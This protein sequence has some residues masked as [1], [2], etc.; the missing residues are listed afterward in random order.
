MSDP[1]KIIITTDFTAASDNALDYVAALL[2]QGVFEVQPSYT[3]VHAYKPLTPYSK[4]PSIPVIK[5]DQLEKT[6]KQKLNKLQEVFAAKT[7][8][9]TPVNKL[10]GRGALNEVLREEITDVQL[11]VMGS[12][13]K[14]AFRRMT[15]G[16]NTLEV[17]NTVDCPLLAIPDKETTHQLKKI[18]MATALE[19]QTISDKSLALLQQM[20]A[21]GSV[22]L[23]VVHVFDEDATDMEATMSGSALHQ[24]LSGIRHTHRHLVANDIAAALSDH[25]D[26][27]RPD[28]IAMAPA[29][30]SFFDKIFHQSKTEKMIYHEGIPTLILT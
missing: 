21:S 26:S 1:I 24:Q 30:R 20:T 3:L 6:L 19:G 5:N 8:P 16:S 7:D 23:E 22:E 29:E 18:T 17:A 11:I 10:F 28:M 2:H 15:V 27:H 4:T 12:R 25:I 13:G 9:A 14:D